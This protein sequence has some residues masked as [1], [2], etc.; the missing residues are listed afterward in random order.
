MSGAVP[1]TILTGFLGA[2]KT[3][4]LRHVLTDPRGLRF[5][6]L[7]NDFGAVN[8]DAALVVESAPDRVALQN[9]CVCCTIRDDLV[10]AL[11]TL[12]EGDTPPDRVIVEASGVSRPLPI[13]DALDAPA[14]GGRLALDGIFC[15]V[16]AGTFGDLDFEATELA[17]DQVAGSDIAI[18]NKTDLA[19]PEALDAIETTLRGALPRLRLVRAQQADVPR[20]LLFGPEPRD[21]LDRHAA[22]H[23]A[24]HHHDHGDEFEA[25]N[26][27]R[28][29][30]LDPARFRDAVRRLPP[31]LMRAK[32]I[33]RPADGNGRLVFQLVGKRWDLVREEAPAPEE[34]T[35]VAIGRRGAFDPAALTAI[36]DACA[37][38]EA[39]IPVLADPA[40]SR[41]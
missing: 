2:G 22:H 1:V 15:L 17:L 30:A 26:W 9:G 28:E 6:V 29:A 37:A 19:T 21:R 25:W 36:F 3:T 16:D 27:R 34:S 20:E 18:L 7:V 39:V 11:A 10:G 31:G 14:L 5:G 23:H 13:A 12:I 38:G 32:A 24:G 4:L 35:V 40:Q 33:I 8:I 41:P